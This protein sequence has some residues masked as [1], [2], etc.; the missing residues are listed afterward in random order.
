MCPG[1]QAGTWASCPQPSSLALACGCVHPFSAPQ[2]RWTPSARVGTPA[3][4]M[5]SLRQWAQE[6]FPLPQTTRVRPLHFSNEP[7]ADLTRE[8]GPGGWAGLRAA[9]VPAVLAAYC[10][11]GQG[12]EWGWGGLVPKLGLAVEQSGS[13]VPSLEGMCCAAWLVCG[14]LEVGSGW[15]C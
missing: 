11:S 4:G 9:L 6:V 13:I 1:A 7:W 14:R 10:L 15:G 8:A 3:V 5:L 2:S 12:W